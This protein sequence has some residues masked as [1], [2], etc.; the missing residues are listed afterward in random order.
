MP[1]GIAPGVPPVGPASRFRRARK[2]C[3]PICDTVAARLR[4]PRCL[5]RLTG[6]VDPVRDENE[7]ADHAC[8]PEQFLGLSCL[9][10]GKAPRDNWLD[11][12]LLKKVEKSDQIP[13][14]ELGLQAFEPL[15]AV[16]N[17]S[18][19]ARKKPASGDVQHEDGDG[20]ET[21][22]TTGAT[23]GQPPPAQRASEPVGHN[24]PAAA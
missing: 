10:K 22:A 9:G 19:P 24:L 8:L 18:P 17:H 13:S 14:E 12:L 5:V 4:R 23:R 2:I 15:D 7:L 6:G 21:V 11:L 16:G 3:A 1:E 20:P